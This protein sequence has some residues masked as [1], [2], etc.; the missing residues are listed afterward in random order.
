MQKRRER[1]VFARETE[2][3]GQGDPA[4]V[5]R[6]T[7]DSGSD[8]LCN[9]KRRTADTRGAEAA[10][11]DRWASHEGG[12]GDCGSG[13]DSGGDR[14]GSG[15][16]SHEGSGS[17]QRDPNES[18][19]F[20]GL[21]VQLIKAHGA[22]RRCRAE[23]P[24]EEASEQ[25]VVKRSN[26]RSAFQG[27]QIISERIQGQAGAHDERGADSGATPAVLRSVIHD[28][29]R[30]FYELYGP[31]LPQMPMDALGMVPAPPYF[32]TYQYQ[33]P[34]VPPPPAPMMMPMA[35]DESVTDQSFMSNPFYNVLQTTR[36][37]CNRRAQA[38][39]PVPRRRDSS[40]LEEAQT[41]KLVE[42]RLRESGQLIRADNTTATPR[43]TTEN[44]SNAGGER[45]LSSR[46]QATDE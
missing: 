41:A 15:S 4:R 14:T 23:L 27:F 31:I 22:R 25:V 6:A 11:I 16:G 39:L 2:R 3:R 37:T 20:R 32:D 24:T 7:N 33:A 8:N 13:G 12:S 28:A 17:G 30:R 42:S 40:L 10:A 34:I 45:S 35:T 18:D 29:S 1:Q 43:T 19:K 46:A 44:G 26:S 36:I 5:G 21:S 9:E 38:P